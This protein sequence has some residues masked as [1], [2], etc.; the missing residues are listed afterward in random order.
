MSDV[1]TSKM[2]QDNRFHKGQEIK[3][4]KS[5][6]DILVKLGTS[7]EDTQESMEEKHHI[8]TWPP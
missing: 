8:S 1:L 6:R 4:L 3:R 7:V 5:T 2:V